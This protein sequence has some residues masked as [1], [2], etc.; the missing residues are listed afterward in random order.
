MYPDSPGSTASLLLCDDC[1]QAATGQ[2]AECRDGCLHDDFDHY[3][4]CLRGSPDECQWC[5]SPDR[6]H[7]VP[8]AGVQ[9][10]LPTVGEEDEGMWWLRFTDGRQGPFSSSQVAW[11]TWHTLA[12]G[13]SI[14][15]VP[16][17]GGLNEARTDE[18]GIPPGPGTASCLPA[19]SQRPGS[20]GQVIRALVAA[21][22]LCS[23]GSNGNG[24]KAH[25][26]PAD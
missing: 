12:V 8:R 11:D 20:Y 13:L 7:E 4:L 19:T 10:Y 26:R 22:D 15:W 18:Q 16:V 24:T 6:L 3:G 5:S 14:G 9:R 21:S 2:L 23:E 25:H 1:F 17:S